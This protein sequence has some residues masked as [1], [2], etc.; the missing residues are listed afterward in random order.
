MDEFI[1]QGKRR[2]L[3]ARWTVTGLLTTTAASQI[4][5]HGSDYCDQTFSREE[6]DRVLLQGSSLGGALRRA[7]CDRLNGYRTNTKGLEHRLFGDANL[8]ESPLIV[9][10][11]ISIEQAQPAI[12]DGVKIQS[13]TGTA[14]AKAKYDRE[15]A[16]AGLTFP[17]R[18]D[19]CID[20]CT[21]ENRENRASESELMAHLAVLLDTL[22]DGGIRFGARKSRGLGATRATSFAA[23]RYD[24]QKEAGWLEYA[25]SR[26]EIAG[27][28]HTKTDKRPS[29]AILVAVGEQEALRSQIASRIQE[30][31]SSDK[32]RAL[33]LCFNVQLDSTVIVRSPGVQ[34]GDS[35]VKHLSE[36]LGALIPGTSL[37]GVLRSE[38]LR[39]L[40][41]IAPDKEKQNNTDLARLFG[42]AASKTGS[43]KKSPTASR[44]LTTEAVING[45]RSYRQTRVKIDRFTGGTVD[46][47]LLEEEP[48]VRGG[49]T[50][51]VE[52]I[53][54][55]DYE[56]GLLLFAA[57]D[58]AGGWLT[59]GGG[60]A[61]GR[62]VLK[63]SVTI[64]LPDGETIVMPE[65]GFQPGEDEPV[66]QFVSALCKHMEDAR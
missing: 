35:D 7:L 12:R 27:E 2:K 56:I 38:C 4:G 14:D 61:I 17:I 45:N 26:A 60:A 47:A 65:G 44:V 64:R 66:K 10:D 58:L 33:S 59:V 52:I 18:F 43:E 6:D 16:Q 46:G 37:A 41:T 19:V 49:T 31:Q 24:L 40:N 3:T 20:Q 9:F 63:G 55:E 34:A 13:A 48:V 53:N 23:R 32:R 15:I 21:N 1:V 57:R 50:F 42:D 5:S 30:V 25:H 54:P 51:K 39:I 22:A 62:G 28:L 29:E 8:H 36:S 11:S